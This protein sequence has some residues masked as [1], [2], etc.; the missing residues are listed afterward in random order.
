MA[1][2]ADTPELRQ[3]FV[4]LLLIRFHICGHADPHALQRLP[5]PVYDTIRK[6]LKQSS[7]ISAQLLSTM[8]SDFPL[9]SDDQ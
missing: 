5:T 6:L 2:P 9:Q 1:I 8:A 3:K 7:K 4:E